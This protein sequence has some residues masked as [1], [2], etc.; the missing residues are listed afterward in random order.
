MEKPTFK[1]EKIMVGQNLGPNCKLAK[2]GIYAAGSIRSVNQNDTVVIAS[3][4]SD[5]YFVASEDIKRNSNNS[6]RTLT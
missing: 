1:A 4:T 3:Q 6:T 2:A 5:E